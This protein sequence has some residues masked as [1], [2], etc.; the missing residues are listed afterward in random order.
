[1]S[2]DP[3]KVVEPAVISIIIALAML[4]AIII[5][6]SLTPSIVREAQKLAEALGG[7]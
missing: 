7:G 1:V 4:P 3:E 6:V 2:P 5:V